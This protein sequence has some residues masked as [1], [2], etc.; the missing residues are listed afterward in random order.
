MGDI[1]YPAPAHQVGK[2]NL[3]DA[4]TLLEIVGWSVDMGYWNGC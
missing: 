3:I 1:D 2:R 4:C